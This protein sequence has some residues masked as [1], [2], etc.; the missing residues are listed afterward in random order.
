MEEPKTVR[1][2]EL[3]LDA[4][5]GG[6]PA[7]RWLAGFPFSPDRPGGTTAAATEFTVVYNEIEPG[8][9]IGTH[10]DAAAELLFVL[11]GRVE[12]TVGEETTTVSAGSLTVLPAETEHRVRNN[13]TQTGELVGVFGTAPVESTFETEPVVGTADHDDD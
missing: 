12:A 11:T 4:V 7:A 8:N 2:D 10:T 9:R 3:D 1:F 13:G 5:D 6:E